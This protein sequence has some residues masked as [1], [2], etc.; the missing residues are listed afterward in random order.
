M[1]SFPKRER[2]KIESKCFN[3]GFAFGKKAGEV[4][5]GKKKAKNEQKDGA[6]SFY[7]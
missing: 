5:R 3:K 2:V 4:D 1:K 6:E 7:L